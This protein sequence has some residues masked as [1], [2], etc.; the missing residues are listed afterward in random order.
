M[1]AAEPFW[2]SESRSISGD[3]KRV[4]DRPGLWEKRHEWECSRGADQTSLSQDRMAGAPYRGRAAGRRRHCPEVADSAAASRE[5]YPGLT[6]EL[7]QTAAQPHL[8][9]A[10]HWCR[11]AMAQ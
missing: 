4:R 5:R 8:A 7:G 9:G 2:K 3:K 10:A 1:R 11:L 6:G